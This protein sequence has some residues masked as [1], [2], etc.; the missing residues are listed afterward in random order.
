MSPSYWGPKSV[1][2]WLVGVVTILMLYVGVNGFLNPEAAIQG[3][4][5]PLKDVAD[6]P[7]VWVKA[8]RDLFIGVFMLALMVLRMRKASLVFLLAT[9]GSPI[10]DAIIVLQNAVDKT[11]AWIHIVTVVYM[12]IVSWMLYQQ[13][14]KANIS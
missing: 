8:D 3:F 6:K 9:T 13:E 7:I 5:L 1:T 11:P 4:G 10:F 2:F 12:L 14:K